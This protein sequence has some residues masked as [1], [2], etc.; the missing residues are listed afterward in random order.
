[1]TE[2]EIARALYACAREAGNSADKR[3]LLIELPPLIAALGRDI[4]LESYQPD[5]MTAFAVRD[6]KL[7]EILAPAFRDRLAQQWLISAI[8]PTIERAWIDDCY[9]NRAGKGTHGAITRLQGF[10]R[11]AGHGHY[12]QMDIRSFFPTINRSILLDLWR[13]ELPRLPYPADT[14]RQLDAVARSI[15]LQDPARPRPVLS[16]SAGLLRQIPPHKSL[17]HAPPGIGLP[18][19]SLSSQF[20]SNVY[21]NPLDQFVKHQLKIRG[22]LRYVDDLIILGDDVRALLDQK[23]R[24]NDFLGER[25]GLALHPDKTI[26]QRVDQGANFLGYIVFPH[27]AYVRERTLRALNKRIHF[28]NH[29]L[30]PARFPHRSLPERGTWA[31][32]LALHELTPP[33]APTPVVLTRMLAT[34]NS[35]FGQLRHADT[36]HLRRRLYHERLG[37]IK[38]FFLPDGP[39]YRALR[40]KPVWLFPSP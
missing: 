3:R 33:L 5:R 4:H 16:G 37:P 40:V 29:L 35:Y 7:R 20:F 39:G 17:F 11:M 19:G 22:Y 23:R 14:L 30:D 36:Y 8:T 32:W 28:F 13:A 18:I 1:M 34:L 27:H 25:L 24:I 9:S 21:L 26:L 31:K 6:P 38:R 12:C 10:M 15:I 2:I